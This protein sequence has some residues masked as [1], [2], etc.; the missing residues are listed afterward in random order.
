MTAFANRLER[1]ISNQGLSVEYQPI[2]EVHSS[3][4]EGFEALVRWN[5]PDLGEV[6]PAWFIPVAEATGLIDE[7]GGWVLETAARQVAAWSHQGLSTRVAVNVSQVALAI[8]GYADRA[9]D[10]IL[11]AGASPSAITVEVSEGAATAGSSQLGKATRR[12]RAL[13]VG[14]AI[15]AFGTE[16]SNLARLS[17]TEFDQ[18]KLDGAFLNAVP[19]NYRAE[20]IVWSLINLG[21]R[22]GVDV[23]VEGVE[24]RQQLLFLLASGCR[25]A[26]GF[27]LG[28][29]MAVD[30]ATEL[31]HVQSA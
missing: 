26:Q 15:D 24:N 20:A 21:H 16:R 9:H 30:L 14:V 17:E 31:L 19:D 28:R 25:L 8:P 12:L 29:P 2:I 1:A 27:H 23:V 5:D 18:L 6:P 3:A 11:A 7:L 13:G 10:L 4:V 22:L